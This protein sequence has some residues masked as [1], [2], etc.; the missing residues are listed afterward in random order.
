MAKV[1]PHLRFG[2]LT[3]RG[4]EA[5]HSYSALEVSDLREMRGPCSGY[6]LGWSCR[7][8]DGH[9]GAC[10]LRPT[11]WNRTRLARAV[12]ARR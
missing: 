6:H 12:R 1:T 4:Q 9:G 3:T 11:W 7:L 8:W 10:P 5:L 2:A